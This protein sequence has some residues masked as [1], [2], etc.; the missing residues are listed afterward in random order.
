MRQ[1]VTRFDD[2]SL[3]SF[4]LRGF[5]ADPGMPGTGPDP[6]FFGLVKAAAR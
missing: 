3:P 2:L 1:L 5:A 4:P 6:G